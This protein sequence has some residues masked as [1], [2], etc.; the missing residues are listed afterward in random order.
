MSSVEAA[1]GPCPGPIRVDGE[2]VEKRKRTVDSVGLVRASPIQRD[3]PSCEDPPNRAPA[4]N[5]TFDAEDREICRRGVRARVL[6]RPDV[7]RAHAECTHTAREPPPRLDADFPSAVE[8]DTAAEEQDGSVATEPSGH[9]AKLKQTLIFQKELAL[10]RKEEAEACEVDLFLVG[11][12]LR[13]VRVVGEVGGEVLRHTVFHIES[14]VAPDV[15]ADSGRGGGIRCQIGY[16]IWFELEAA[17]PGWSL[18][19][20]ECGGCGHLKDA[21]YA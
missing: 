14:S 6:I 7:E 18:D 21:S 8:A 9:A 3:G 19:A 1:L 5:V 10:F 13:E 20:D 16:R 4:Q 11:F 17:G 15:I 2:I 12:N